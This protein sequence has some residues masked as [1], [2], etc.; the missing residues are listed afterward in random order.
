[1]QSCKRCV[2]SEGLLVHLSI[3]QAILYLIITGSIEGPFEHFLH[4]IPSWSYAY[5]SP[6]EARRGMSSI[7]IES[8]V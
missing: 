2:R 7:L 4:P 1:M 6:G 3:R 8:I 5:R